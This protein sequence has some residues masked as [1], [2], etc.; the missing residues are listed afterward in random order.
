MRNGTP[1][2]ARSS[3]E[4]EF[5]DALQ[6]LLRAYQFRDREQVFRCGISATAC[7]AL[8]HI[9][10]AGPVTVKELATALRLDKSTASRVAASLQDGG[11]VGRTP[12]ATDRRAAWLAATSK[13]RTLHR[14]IR[15]NLMEAQAPLIADLDAATLR[16]LT[17]ILGALSEGAT[18]TVDGDS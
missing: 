18:R 1:G 16:K 4:E 7:Y 9:V 11:H 12:H 15:K 13:G 2:S 6:R 3:E 14:R 5:F 8:E 17:A 10:R